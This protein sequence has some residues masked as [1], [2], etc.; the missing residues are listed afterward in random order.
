MLIL[1]AWV[2]VSISIGTAQET[3]RAVIFGRVT[4][5]DT[6][7]PVADAIVYL[8]ETPF[9]ASTQG[10]G[11]Y[12][13]RGIPG[14]EFTL[15]VTRLG[16]EPHAMAVRTHGS[17]SLRVDVTLKARPVISPG[18]DIFGERGGPPANA[19][20]GLL[21]PRPDPGTYCLYSASMSLPI[22]LFQTDSALFMYLLTPVLVDSAK[23]MRLWFYYR[24]LSQTPLDLDPMQCVALHVT[25]E[26]RKPSVVHPVPAA[27]MRES[28]DNEAA[29]RSI[30][31]SIGMCFGKNAATQSTLEERNSRMQHGAFWD[32]PPFD[33]GLSIGYVNPT[34]T[35]SSFENS[36]ND[37]VL[38]RHL[39]FPGNGVHGY[40]YFPL[41]GADWK[42]AAYWIQDIL[43]YRYELEIKTPLGRHLI[44][45]L[46]G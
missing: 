6:G 30:A 9:G 12:R 45:F 21:F 3:D 20:S 15:I 2:M 31:D 33:W 46:P 18:V 35:W 1:V 11:F 41:P 32:L 4:D 24:N 29:V 43:R 26:S 28:I 34:V 16:Y 22:G 38:K 42:A 39:V 19:G 37:G 25:R 8:T 5:L 40:V 36:Q 14:G 13:I 23:Y 17:D 10:D 7:A 44:H 27:M